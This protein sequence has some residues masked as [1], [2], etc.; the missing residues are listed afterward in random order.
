MTTTED[1]RMNQVSRY[2]VEILTS[3]LAWLLEGEDGTS[4]GRHKLRYQSSLAELKDDIFVATTEY[5][6]STTM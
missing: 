4:L 5:N 6:I 2:M 3:L 1:L